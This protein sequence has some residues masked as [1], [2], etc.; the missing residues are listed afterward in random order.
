[1]DLSKILQ[2]LVLKKYL[3]KNMQLTLSE[4][5]YNELPL[6]ELNFEG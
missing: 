2:E 6:S 3:E 1:V 5:L 4:K